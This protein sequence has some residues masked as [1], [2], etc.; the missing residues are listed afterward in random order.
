MAEHGR[1][2]VKI[3]DLTDIDGRKEQFSRAYVHAV[4]TVCG[5]LLAYRS[6]DKDSIDLSVEAHDRSF[7]NT[8]VVEAGAP[9]LD[10]QLKC[11][12]RS[13]IK[14]D[15]L[16][17]PLSIKNYDDL[18]RPAWSPRL[19]VVVVVPDDV[20]R[21]MT[22]SPQELVLHGAG[23]YRSLRDARS[24]SNTTS[25]TVEVPLANPFNVESLQSIMQSAAKREAV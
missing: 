24:V 16:H 2:P 23:Y 1:T 8:L 20:E 22:C 18:R 3:V 15:T 9:R 21:W 4:A 25:V 17:Y 5:Y 10:L 6:A 19:L 11:T 14:G 12:S 7:G 13:L